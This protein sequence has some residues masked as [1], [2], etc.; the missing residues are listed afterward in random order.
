MKYTTEVYDVRCNFRI[1]F[2]LNEFIS[3]EAFNSK[4]TEYL[5]KEIKSH[6]PSYISV[7]DIATDCETLFVV[8]E[9]YADIFPNGEDLSDYKKI[10][11]HAIEKYVREERLSKE[12]SKSVIKGRLNNSKLS[13][14]LSYKLEDFRINSECD[15]EVYSY[16]NSYVNLPVGTYIEDIY[17]YGGEVSIKI[18]NY[19]DK[20]PDLDLIKTIDAKLY[21]A[22]T[23]Y[24]KEGVKN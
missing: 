16:I 14:F 20:S 2:K 23:E 1:E 19:S 4:I 12:S 11:S 9:Y 10:I 21:Y 24:A 7:E 18:E 13:F 8:F 6:L 15:N 17:L 22:L 3:G 5:D